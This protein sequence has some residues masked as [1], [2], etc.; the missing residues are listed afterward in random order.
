MEYIVKTQLAT[1]IKHLCDYFTKQT[2]E[3]TIF[4]KLYVRIQFAHY[5]QQTASPVRSFVLCS[6]VQ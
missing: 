4:S 1:S 5:R 2:Y 6:N 3:D